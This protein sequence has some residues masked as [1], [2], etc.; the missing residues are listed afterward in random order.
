MYTPSPKSF[1]ADRDRGTGTRHKK[2][3][4]ELYR[5]WEIKRTEA[6]LKMVVETGRSGVIFCN[7]RSTKRWEAVGSSGKWENFKFSCFHFVY[8]SI[9]GTRER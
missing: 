6:R 2:G 9:I 5:K 7:K 3:R 1:I 8:T 4:Q